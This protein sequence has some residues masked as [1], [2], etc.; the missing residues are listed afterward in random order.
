LLSK[1][2]GRRGIRVNA[3]A[4]GYFASEM[5]DQFDIEYFDSAIVPHKLCGRLGEPEELSA[6][7]LFLASDASSYITGITLPSKAECSPP[8]KPI[9]KRLSGLDTVHGDADDLESMCI[10]ARRKGGGRSG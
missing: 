5:T 7:Q 1:W 6:A 2:T 3:I 8:R 9:A 4:P 10:P